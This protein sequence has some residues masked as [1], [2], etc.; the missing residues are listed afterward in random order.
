MRAHC[1]NL[2]SPRVQP[3]VQKY[4]RF[5]PSLIRHTSSRT[6]ERRARDPARNP[7]HGICAAPYA[8]LHACWGAYAHVVQLCMRMRCSLSGHVTLQFLT[9]L[10][11]RRIHTLQSDFPGSGQRSECH[12]NAWDRAMVCH[13]QTLGV[14][15]RQQRQV[16][17][18]V[19][20]IR[21][22]VL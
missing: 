21:A 7:L 20:R 13:L 9:Q 22:C 11:R 10:Y 17:T 15:R 16:F 3:E 4:A 5:S 14:G 12:F 19:K 18:F 2:E 8:F 1:R 6:G